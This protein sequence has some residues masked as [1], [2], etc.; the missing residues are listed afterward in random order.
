MTL[1]DTARSTLVLVD[2]QGR[3]LPMIDGHDV[4]LANAVLLAD[5]AR[6]IGVPVIGTE[7]NPRGLGPNHGEIR[8]RC[9]S[10]LHKMHFDACADGLVERLRAAGGEPPAEVVIAGC[11]AHV[12]L[13]Q[14]ALGL[15]RAGLAVRV[16]APACGSRS[17]ENKTLAM[18]RLHA[19]G[20]TLVSVE[21]V[22]FEWLRSCEHPR[23]KA[24]LALLKG[25]AAGATE[26][27]R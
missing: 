14:T 3:L 27:T 21:M 10:T 22:A 26:I 19:A 4:V 8:S 2:Y 15:L 25:G 5:V 16:V 18:Q 20:A 9:A 24:V 7:Q 23:F 6:S 1:L 17:A 12:C 11:E 13:M